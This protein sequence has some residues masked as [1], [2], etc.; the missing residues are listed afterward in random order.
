MPTTS[1]GRV[2]L[3]EVTPRTI[4]RRRLAVL[5]T[6]LVVA[7]LGVAGFMSLRTVL[8]D[9]LPDSCVANT[10]RASVSLSAEQTANAATIAALSIKRGMPPRAATIAIATAMQES[11]LRNLRV[12]DRDSV[13]LFQQRP[14]QGWG[15]AQ[16][17]L[18]PEYATNAFY[19]ALVKVKDYTG[20]PLTEVA[21]EVQRSGHPGAYA[22]HEDEAEV[23]S[24]VLTG[25][26]STGLVCQL[27]APTG[28]G[29]PAAVKAALGRQ[30]GVSATVTGTT[31]Q[32]DAADAVA[33]A[34]GAWAVAHAQGRS[35]AR[36]R[37]ADRSWTRS[38]PKTWQPVKG[39]A[40]VQIEVSATG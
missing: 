16:Q 4:R 38:D 32:V 9:V 28:A 11:K 12:G 34:A 39:A 18:D 13:G 23:L 31:I 25:A 21:Q 20:R 17:I 10:G 24:A 19:D 14:S 27:D 35:V 29:D 26:A 8:V 3:A 22:Q 37:V 5:V 7:I 33:W 40:G 2:V 30:L 36:V 15:T 1:G 6:V